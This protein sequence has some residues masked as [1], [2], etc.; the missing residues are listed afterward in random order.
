MVHPNT[1][2]RPST[3]LAGVASLLPAL[4]MATTYEDLQVINP[5]IQP[6]G[7]PVSR[8]DGHFYGIGRS[9]ERSTEAVIYRVAPGQEAEILFTFPQLEIAGTPNNHG[10]Y[11]DGTLVAGKDGSFYGA[12]GGGGAHGMGTLFR[13]S[14]DGTFHVL[15]DFQPQDGFGVQR[16]VAT[17]AGEVLGIMSHGGPEGGGT[18]F[19]VTQDGTFQTEHAFKSPTS[20]PPGTPVPP[21]ARQPPSSPTNLAIGP[22]GLVYGTTSTGGLIEASARFQ[23]TYG[24]FFRLENTGDITVLGEFYPYRKNVNSLIPT[25]NG[26]VANSQRAL[27]Q[28]GLDG[29]IRLEADFT[30]IG[31]GDVSLWTPVATSHGVYGISN[32]GGDQAG[33]FIYHMLPQ[34]GTSI[35]HHFPRSFFQCRSSLAKGNDGLVYGLADFMQDDAPAPHP[36]L[37]RLFRLHDAAT[38]PNRVPVAGPDEAWL[39]AKA[40]D[41]QREVLIDILANDQDPDSD[42]LTIFGL[43]GDFGAG[44]AELV[45][46]PRGIRLKFSTPEMSPASRMITYQFTDTRGGI[47]TGYVAIKSPAAGWYSGLASG[48]G[49]EGAPL[50]VSLS[51]NNLAVAIFELNG[52]KYTGQGTIDAGDTASVALSATG[53][54]TLRLHLELHRGAPNSLKAT[55][56]TSEAVYHATCT[57]ADGN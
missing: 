54:P 45:Q 24:C 56:R 55:I 2:S 16:L 51:K 40:T 39:P 36:I 19:R 52:V 50:G 8:G 37:P 31:N 22:D 28:I 10:S 3:L 7:N 44:S 15:Y 30:T 53:Q 13:W 17:A 23:F 49:L 4:A 32:Y 43:S 11:P 57:T 33:G 27:F 26:F 46:T 42:P 6:W 9:F 21:G 1:F 34:G 5:R 35:I 38:S 47:S 20:Y 25:D 14:S 48:H 29:T 12:T 18:I 41:G